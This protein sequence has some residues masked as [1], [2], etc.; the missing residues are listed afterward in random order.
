VL[1]ED[2][3][4]GTIT[5]RK[6]PSLQGPSTGG[7]CMIWCILIAELVFL[8]PQLTTTEIVRDIFGVALNLEKRTTINNIMKGYIVEIEKDVTKY[9]D[10]FLKK[11]GYRNI[12][13][14]R[15]NKEREQF[16]ENLFYKVLIPKIKK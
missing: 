12:K 5:P 6:T 16:L 4:Y 10:E 7:T 2:D 8:N 14:G 1:V 15:R 3:K 9:L 13:Y 11:S